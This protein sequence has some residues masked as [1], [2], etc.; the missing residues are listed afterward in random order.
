MSDSAPSGWRHSE[1]IFLSKFHSLFLSLLTG[2]QLGPLLFARQLFHGNMKT[3]Q[4]LVEERAF[5]AS[6]CMCQETS[7]TASTPGFS[8]HAIGQTCFPCSR[9]INY[10][11][12]NGIIVKGLGQSE[13]TPPFLLPVS[14][15][16]CVFM[17]DLLYLL[18]FCWSFARNSTLNFLPG[19]SLFIFW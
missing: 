15:E 17:W 13:N 18:F 4:C 5:S 10:R 14:W 9:L 16:R 6:L 8:S 2:F 1:L 3:W 12:K 7:T 11:H 19:N